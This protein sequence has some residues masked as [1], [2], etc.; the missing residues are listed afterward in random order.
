MKNFYLLILRELE[1]DKYFFFKINKINREINT[2]DVFPFELKIS[3]FN[4]ILILDEETTPASNHKS[5]SQNH[6]GNPF[7]YRIRNRPLMTL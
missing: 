6:E 7:E 2:Y 3:S 5:E 4:V 1:S